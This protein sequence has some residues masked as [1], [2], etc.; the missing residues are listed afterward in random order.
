MRRFNQPCGENGNSIDF[1]ALRVFQKFTL[2]MQAQIHVRMHLV[3]E[4][5]RSSGGTRGPVVKIELMRLTEAKV[6]A[7]ALNFVFDLSSPK[8]TVGRV[9]R[10]VTSSFKKL[11]RRLSTLWVCARRLAR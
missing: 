11:Y 7:G 6:V 4:D 2:R 10:D 1:S 3:R 5:G 9:Y 8:L